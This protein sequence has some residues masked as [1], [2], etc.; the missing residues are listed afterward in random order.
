MKLTKKVLGLSAVALLAVGLAACG[1]DKEDNKDT[2]ENSTGDKSEAV[3]ETVDYK[4]TGIDPGAGIMEAT[5]R[6]I[7]DYDLDEWSVVTGS[8]A[9][10]TAALK[11]AYDK[12][13]PIII[14][15]WSPHWK[16]AKY[17]LKYLED[18]EGSYGGSEELHTITRLGLEDD[19][20][21]AHA[22]LQN[23]NW[24][25]ED[26][27]EVMIEVIDGEKPEVAAQNWIDKNEEKVTEWT[28][29]IDKVDGDEI[30][31]VYVSWDS[32]VASTNVVALVLEDLGYEVEMLQVEAG[33][34]W[35][36]I[37]DGSA[38]VLLAGWLPITHGT[39]AEKFEGKYEDI[40][41]SMVD[42]KIGLVVPTY[43]DID[44]IEDLK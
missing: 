33:P 21:E 29:G 15:G 35:A 14:T 37:A 24:L 9:A 34:M 2:D 43:M 16:F 10:M 39:Y 41:T 19:F 8:G 28:D 3:G 20:P 4:I 27:A 36:A 40:G 22:M 5:D 32:A 30:K 25:E 44:S 11:K 7:E 12:E 13:E 1:N 26:M 23:F 31:F 38:D 42:V 18:P 17:D 6:A